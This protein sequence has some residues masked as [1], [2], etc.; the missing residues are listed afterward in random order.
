MAQRLAGATALLAF[1]ICLLI[2]G[3]QVGNSF[4]TTVQRALVALV[5]TFV[6]GL[7]VGAM[8]QKMIDENAKKAQPEKSEN[9]E[10]KPKAADR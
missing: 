7:I 5:G 3:L 1:A 6:I 4:T 9:P 10:T 8:G 2:G